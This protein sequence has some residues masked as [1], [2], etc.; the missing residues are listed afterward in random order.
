[1]PAKFFVF[2]AIFG[3]MLTGSSAFALTEIKRAELI[4]VVLDAIEHRLDQNGPQVTKQADNTPVSTPVT[5][6]K[7][8]NFFSDFTIRSAFLDIL[9]LHRSYTSPITC[10]NTQEDIIPDLPLSGEGDFEDLFSLNSFDQ[11]WVKLNLGVH[12][13]YFSGNTNYQIGFNGGKSELEFSLKSESVIG[14][15]FALVFPRARFWW[16][17]AGYISTN[18]ES[19]EMQDSDWGTDDVLTS[20][21]LSDAF[22]KLYIWDSSVGYVLWNGVY[23]AEQHDWDMALSFLGGF[24]H[25]H[26]KYMIYNLRDVSETIT[27]DVGTA[28]VLEY[29]VKY[30][31]PYLGFKFN[32]AQTE[33]VWGL[34]TKAAFSPFAHAEDF[35]DHLLRGK[36]SISV[37]NGWAWLVGLNLFYHLNDALTLQG[38]VDYANIRTAGEQVQRWYRAEGA[39]PAG[40]RVTGIDADII[41][42][43][44]Y[45]WG[46]FN[47]KF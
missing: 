33:E 17:G 47:Y 42:N 31:L 23:A 6:T 5:Y 25:E 44:V 7:P 43:Q 11:A 32:L 22:L 41:S 9:A 36:R 8:A 35:D 15:K 46:R 12:Y 30:D 13:G 39:V 34:S 24:R 16:E 14:P 21:T 10:F 37:C 29:R 20:D 26:F 27:V 28:P 4:S 45:Y 38:G 19:G 1:M 18:D 2:V 40:T 3:L